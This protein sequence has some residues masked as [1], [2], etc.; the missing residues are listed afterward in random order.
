MGRPQ[1]TE[2]GPGRPLFSRCLLL[3]DRRADI[4][5]TGSDRAHAAVDQQFAAGDEAAVLRC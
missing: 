3:E 5:R 2:R 1:R 4:A